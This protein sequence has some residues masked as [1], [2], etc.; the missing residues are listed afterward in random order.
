MTQ[1]KL[2]QRMLITVLFVC[3]C[4]DVP[5]PAI[6]RSGGE[7]N[8]AVG[9]PEQDAITSSESALG[10]ADAGARGRRCGGPLGLRCSSSEYCAIPSDGGCPNAKAYGT[11]QQ[12]TRLCP[13]IFDPVCGC[14]GKTYSNACSAAAA[15]VAVQYAGQCVPNGPSC[16]GFAGVACPGEGACVDDP[17]DDCDPQAGGADCGGVCVCR[18]PHTCPAGAR[19]DS[20]PSV[21]ACVHDIIPCPTAPCAF[22]DCAAGSRCVERD[23]K[24]FCEPIGGSCPPCPPGVEC[25]DVCNP[26]PALTQ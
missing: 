23:C 14:D 3:G 19:F 26:G 1:S 8:E 21:C 18:D 16:G 11:C 24:A 17:R 7:E 25:T 15:G 5:E 9:D 10:A 6:S 12:N 13:Q 2:M 20:G 22:T 4:A